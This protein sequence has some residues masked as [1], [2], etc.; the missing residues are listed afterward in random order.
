MTQSSAVGLPPESDP[1][2]SAVD[3]REFVWDDLR[4]VLALWKTAGPG[5]HLGPSDSPDELRKKW[6]QDPDLFLVAEAGGDLIAAVL[7]GFD[8][9]RGIVYHLAVAEPWRRRGIGRRMMDEL[10]QRL[11]ARGCLKSYLLATPENHE[12]VAFYRG[13]GWEV[14]DMVLMGK[15]L[16]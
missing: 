6:I 1:G 12:A 9:R 4:R 13:L 10:E 8:G 14:M 2:A 3:L 5:I 11:R 7:G 15:E 16:A